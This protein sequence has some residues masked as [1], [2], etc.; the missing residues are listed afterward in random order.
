MGCG[1]SS[2]APSKYATSQPSE[3][4]E[5]GERSPAMAKETE[6]NT[7]T[8]SDDDAGFAHAFQ[9]RP[10][11]DIMETK[12]PLYAM[13]MADFLSLERL[14]PHNNLLERGLVTALDLDGEHRGVQV[15][16]VSHQWLGYTTADPNGEHL[17]TMQAAFR[18]AMTEP[19]ALFKDDADWKAY[20]TG[21][22]EANRA[23]LENAA[24]RRGDA[25]MSMKGVENVDMEASQEAF[26][27]SVKDGWV[28]ALA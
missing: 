24:K 3:P 27:A 23:T 14:E 1:A 9:S 11:G 4:A 8:R 13:K 25:E 22:T 2:T 21:F 17:R 20:A 16:F 5:T 7:P 28:R 10:E 12:Y 15:Q 26:M 18:R 6:T 19:S